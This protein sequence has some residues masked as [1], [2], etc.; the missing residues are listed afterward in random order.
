MHKKKQG[1]GSY[2]NIYI[3]SVDYDLSKSLK[4][5]QLRQHCWNKLE[6]LGRL[7]SDDTLTASWLPILLSHIGSQV[8]RRQSHSYK[9]K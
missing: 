3:D 2:F 9:F 8:K 4:R 1:Y 6:Q 5:T 7:R